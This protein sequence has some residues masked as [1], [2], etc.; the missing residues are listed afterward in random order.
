[1]TGHGTSAAHA[2]AHRARPRPLRIVVADDDPDTVLTLTMLLEDEGHVV[3]GVEKGDEVMQL[4]RRMGPDAVI[5]DIAM[6]GQSGFAVAQDIRAAYYG[7]R[8][9][10]LIAITGHYKKPT[11]RMLSQLV[12]FDHHLVKPYD[13]QELIDLLGPLS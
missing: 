7:A 8:K 13:S 5:L 12:G 2:D 9:P 3:Q 11:D 4:V 6:P 10:L 1:M